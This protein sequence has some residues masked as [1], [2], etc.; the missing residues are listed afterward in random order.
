MDNQNTGGHGKKVRPEAI[1]PVTM[2]VN[3]IFQL[4][5]TY[6]FSGIL[7]LR[8]TSNKKYTSSLNPVF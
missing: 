5:E 3:L 4:Q 6:N 2:K 8:N 7:E 1:L